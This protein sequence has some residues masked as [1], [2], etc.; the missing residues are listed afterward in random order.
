MTRPCR[1]GPGP[2]LARA[3][4]LLGALLLCS[5]VPALPQEQVQGNQQEKDPEEPRKPEKAQKKS[6]KSAADQEAAAQTEEDRQVEVQ[7]I[8]Q[9]YPAVV[10]GLR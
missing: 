6:E 1:A 10:H 2:L 5:P 3:V 4:L 7:E 9:L 8:E